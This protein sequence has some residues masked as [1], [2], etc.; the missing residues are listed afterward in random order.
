MYE[1]HCIIRWLK[2]CAVLFLVPLCACG[3]YLPPVPPEFVAPAAIESLEIEA[4]I[5]QINFKWQAPAKNQM[6]EELESI[7]GYKIYR[8]ELVNQSDLI[9]P[10]VKYQLLAS[11]VDKHLE[12]LQKLRGEAAEKGLPTRKVRVDS[13]LKQFSYSDS[14]VVPGKVY[15]YK[16]AP[17][18]QGDVEGR[19][20]KI[21]RVTYRGNASEIALID[22]RGG[23]EEVVE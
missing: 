17:F 9:D 10:S 22:Q 8:K 7:D 15:A 6:G 1:K 18:N 21:I 4:D 3:R 20:N 19:V 14:Q 23:E 11:I 16:I 5:Q 2:G 13:S 12:E